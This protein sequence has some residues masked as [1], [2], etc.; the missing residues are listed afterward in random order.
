MSY[1]EKAMMIYEDLQRKVRGTV[2]LRFD[3]FN[4]GYVFTISN[5]P[6][7]FYYS[8][9]YNLQE[10]ESRASYFL[11]DAIIREYEFSIRK[12]FFI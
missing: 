4:F 7:N 12:S 10:I 11:T 2:S 9:F 1:K 6:C 3:A 8:K 5:K